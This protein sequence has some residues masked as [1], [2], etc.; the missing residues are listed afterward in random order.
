MPRRPW[1]D[2]FT[3]G[4]MQRVMPLLPKQGDRAPWLNPQR[5]KADRE[6]LA[7]GPPRRRVLQFTRT[8]S[9]APFALT[10]NTRLVQPAAEPIGD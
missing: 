5:Y 10:R 1:I 6:Q 2:G 7:Q 4:Y 3:P 8:R 9:M